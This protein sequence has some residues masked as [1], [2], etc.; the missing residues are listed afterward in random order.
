[1]NL[2]K[3][4]LVAGLA[5]AAST[6]FL[7]T[8]GIASGYGASRPSAP[9]GISVVALNASKLSVS[10]TAPSSDGGSAVTGYNLTSNVTGVAC[11]TTGALSC[12]LPNLKAGKYNL[13]VTASNRVGTSDPKPAPTFNLKAG[14]YVNTGVVSFSLA[15]SKSSATKG[16]LS[17]VASSK[18]VLKSLKLAALKKAPALSSKK[19]KTGDALTIAFFNSTNKIANISLVEGKKTFKIGKSKSFSDAKTVTVANFKA[20]K[21]LTKGKATLIISGLGKKAISVAV[22][23]VK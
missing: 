4:V 2:K 19:F 23:I 8:S 11:S 14:A 20:P 12:V 22:T 9:S 16:F 13:S 18:S 21:G 17:N 10:W 3:N 6:L 7:V 5:V 15:G 1:M